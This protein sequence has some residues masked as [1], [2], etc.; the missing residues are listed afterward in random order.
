MCNHPY[1]MEG[2]EPTDKPWEE[3]AKLRI[4]ASGK[5]QLLDKMLTVLQQN[6]HRVLIFSQFTS[7]LD[8]LETYVSHRFGATMYQRVDGTMRTDRRQVRVSHRFKREA[9]I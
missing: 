7:M 9:L 8:V 3:C 1:L 5:L 2:T 6:G 4:S